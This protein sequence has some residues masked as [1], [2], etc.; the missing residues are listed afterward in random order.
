MKLGLV[1][2]A[3]HPSYAGSINRR[4]KI[5]ACLAKNERAYPKK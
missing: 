2:C 3:Y 4:I 1:A 5:Q